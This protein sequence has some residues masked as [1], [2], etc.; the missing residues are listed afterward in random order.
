MAIKKD[1]SILPA[2]KLG[3]QNITGVVVCPVL[4][5]KIIDFFNNKKKINKVP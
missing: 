4:M 1:L 3:V 5:L 2:T